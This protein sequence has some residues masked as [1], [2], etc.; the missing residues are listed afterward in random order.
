MLHLLFLFHC[1]AFIIDDIAFYFY[2][3]SVVVKHSFIK[4]KYVITYVNK[5]IF[6]SKRYEHWWHV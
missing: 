1:F 3:W 4:T 6:R 5:L 2:V